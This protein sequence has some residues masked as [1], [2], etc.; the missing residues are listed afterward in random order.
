MR[1]VIGTVNKHLLPMVPVSVQKDVDQWQPLS[2]I[3]DTGFNG[4]I[5]LDE[6]WLEMLGLQSELVGMFPSFNLPTEIYQNSR[7]TPPIRA[8]LIWAGTQRTVTVNA[9]QG[10]PFSG[11][12]GTDLLRYRRVTIDA[13]EGGSVIVDTG[14]A[15]S[16]G[17]LAR[18]MSRKLDRQRPLF[19]DLDEY[20][21]WSMS[22]L[23]WTNL[24]VRDRNGG[25]QAIWVNVDTGY[26]GE[27]SLPTKWVNRLG[28]RLPDRCQLHTV[29]GTIPTECGDV[30]VDWRGEKR[31]IDCTHRPDDSPPLIGM[32]LLEGKRITIEFENEW[33]TVEIRPIPPP[34]GSIQTIVGSL[35]G[36]LRL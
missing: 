25:W 16:R 19:D 1:V 30:E 2:I 10:H 22:N 3:L 24:R 36:R 11:L 9:L 27:L 31:Y 29:R 18:W 13:I 8:E 33:P 28:L 6:K 12:L 15:P 26:T 7:N 4:D 34:P 14:P 35:R 5:A 20:L 23:P 17:H 32:K 21:R